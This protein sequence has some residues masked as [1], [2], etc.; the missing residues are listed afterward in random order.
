MH[1]K[2]SDGNFNQ[3]AYKY[4]L[5]NAG[6]TSTEFEEEIRAETARNILSQSIL[7]GNLTNKLQ[8]QILASLFEER[9]FNIQ[10]LTPEQLSF[11]VKDPVMSN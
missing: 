7:S 4:A 1:L 3:E 8:A 11:N 9:S 5:E 2:E 10:I 6:Y